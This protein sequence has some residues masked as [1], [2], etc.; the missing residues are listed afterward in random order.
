MTAG[1]VNGKYIKIKKDI[2]RGRRAYRVTYRPSLLTFVEGKKFIS[3]KMML[4]DRKINVHIFFNYHILDFFPL[5]S[6]SLFSTFL[7]GIG[8]LRELIFLVSR[9]YI[10]G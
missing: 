3:L 8:K 2:K 4:I 6:S 5:L 10:E 7:K 9:V 1:P